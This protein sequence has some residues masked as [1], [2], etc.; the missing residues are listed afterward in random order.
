MDAKR[1][2][3]S[4]RAAKATYQRAITE[5]KSAKQAQKAAGRTGSKVHRG[6]K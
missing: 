6:K 2:T 5:G 1:K 4:R 3:K